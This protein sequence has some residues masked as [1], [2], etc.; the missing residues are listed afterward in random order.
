MHDDPSLSIRPATWAAFETVM[1][2]KGGCGGCWCML[3]RLS[4]KE[5]A[6][7][8]GQA[9]RQAMQTLFESGDVPGLIAY[10]NRE[11]VGWCQVA[12]R[13]S[14]P[15]LA[16]ARV[17]K[18]VDQHDVWSVSCLLIDKSHRRRGLSVDLLKA[19]AGFVRARGGQ[20]LEGYPVAPRK[21][22]YPA[23]YAW[24]GFERAFLRAGFREVARR[25]ETRPI[26]RLDVH[27]GDPI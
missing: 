27:D 21:A 7:Q 8:M 18:P 23:V 2:P 16:T 22:P 9:N 17:L 6:A 14:F 19:A 10:R 13:R 24:T 3:W 11:P 25:S 4:R 20:I 1:G 26:M 12:P 15:R 5:M